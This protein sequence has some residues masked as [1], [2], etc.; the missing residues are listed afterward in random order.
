MFNSFSL[1]APAE[2]TMA[3]AGDAVPKDYGTCVCVFVGAG[4]G[5]ADMMAVGVGGQHQ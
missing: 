3:V 1:L 4:G 5:R 2:P